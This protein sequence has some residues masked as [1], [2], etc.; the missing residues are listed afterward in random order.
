MKVAICNVQEFDPTIGGIER[1]S[2]SLAECLIKNAVDVI[3]ISCRKSTYNLDYS[4]PARQLFLPK[5]DDYCTE[6]VNALTQI[7]N[8]EEIEVI[9]NQNA[10]SALYNRTCFEAKHNSG[11]KLISA[12]HFSPDMRIKGNRNRFNWNFGGIKENLLNI[13]R[14]ICTRFPFKCITMYDQRNM[15]RKLYKNSDKVILLA[16]DFLPMYKKISGLKESSKLECINNMLSYPY[17]RKTYKKKKQILFVGR[18][19]FSQK[20]PD[21]VLY[22]WKMLQEQMLDW[23]VVFVGDG[24]FL[25][26]LKII[27]RDLSL[28][29]VQFVGFKNPQQYYQES[30]ILC[31]T[32]NH[33]GWGLVLTEAMQYGCVPIAFDSYESVHDII[34]NGYNGFIVKPFD[35]KEFSEKINFLAESGI[36]TFSHNAIS[37]VEKFSPQN[38]ARKWLNV[39]KN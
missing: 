8:D 10:H 38:I 22:I 15:M 5:T 29:R 14:D 26:K 31:M 32:S 37:S 20:R 6:N 1:V 33:E 11:V 7:I 28:K 27:S 25:D 36:S 30:S 18:M 2:V 16:E 4:L 12:F 19:L 13:C 9:I 24:P 34:I 35:L 39:L 21:R 3:F 23:N 17:E